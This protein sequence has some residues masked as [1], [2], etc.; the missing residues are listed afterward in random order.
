MDQPIAQRQNQ[1]PTKATRQ[2]TQQQEQQQQQE[3]DKGV[4][5]G[6]VRPS[7]SFLDMLSLRLCSVVPWGPFVAFETAISS[8]P[9]ARRV[10]PPRSFRTCQDQQQQQQQDG[11]K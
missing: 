1:P 3:N 11:S 7:S 5:G 10:H 2:E 9:V 8:A 6:C 4:L